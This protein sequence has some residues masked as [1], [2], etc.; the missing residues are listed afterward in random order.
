[1][2]LDGAK[3][4]EPNTMNFGFGS[5]ASFNLFLNVGQR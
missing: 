3:Q 2:V 1:M 4:M 5:I